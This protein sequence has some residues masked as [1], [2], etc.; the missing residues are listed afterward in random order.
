MPNY[1]D[2]NKTVIVTPPNPIPNIVSNGATWDSGVMP[3]F[4][5]NQFEGAIISYPQHVVGLTS[6]QDVSVTQQRYLDAD[7]LIPV[8]ANGPVAFLAGVPNYAT[9]SFM[10]IIPALYWRITITNT[11]GFDA[12][13]TNMGIAMCSAF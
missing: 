1:I 12:I 13:I 9:T 10:N 5:V 4:S 7:G 8:G 3:M 6:S 2:R 11:S